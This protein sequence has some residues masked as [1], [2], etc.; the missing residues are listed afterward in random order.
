VRTALALASN[1]RVDAGP[2]PRDYSVDAFD[3]EPPG[4]RVGV[5]V[6]CVHVLSPTAQWSP[7]R[8]PTTRLAPCA[9]MRSLP[10]SQMTLTP[11]LRGL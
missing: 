11:G 2:T 8:R 1:T 7:T 5:Y 10:T 6:C 9:L 3:V 4:V